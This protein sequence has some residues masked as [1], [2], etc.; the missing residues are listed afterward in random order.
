MIF[1]VQQPK[2]LFL[3]PAG[4]G[5]GTQSARLAEGFKLVHISTG[6]L[7]RAEIKSESKLGLEVKAIVA[8]G[9]LVSDDIVN[10][11]VKSKLEKLGDGFILDGY[12][13]TLE[14]AKFLD[15]YMKLDCIFDLQA[16]RE[17]LVRRLSGRRMCSKEKD[18][19]CKGVFHTSYNPPRQEGICDLCRSP[20]Y[21]RSDD[22]EEVIEKRLSGYEE[23]TGIPLNNFYQNSGGTKPQFIKLD[24]TK[25]PDT[26]YGQILSFVKQAD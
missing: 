2:I 6:D 25:D 8:A 17:E 14:Q 23:E 9:K 21:Q 3:G 4:A 22:K 13:R 11:I 1:C 7:I 5:K 20:L 26:V 16:P 10:A 18:P 12:P 19:N 24:A 15:A